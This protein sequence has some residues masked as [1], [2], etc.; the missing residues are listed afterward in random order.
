MRRFE[1]IRHLTWLIPALGLSACL[2]TFDV[3][4]A[5]PEPIKVDLAMDVHVYQHGEKD[6]ESAE[7]QSSYRT[8]MDD[9]R[10]RMA[11]IQELKNSRLIG[12]NRQGK[13]TE[14]NSPAGEYGEYVSK[15]I[16]DEN[17]DREFLIRHEADE[18]GTSVSG[19]RGE[20]WLHWQRKSFPGEW[21][22]VEKED[23]TGYEWVQKQTAAE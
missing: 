10:N 16:A 5:T 4:V 22:E 18:K 14:L 21:I 15:T 13:L 23:G 17:R 2:P 19:V 6:E 8:A 20:Q 12:E 11:E 9:R 7:K 3:N 1:F